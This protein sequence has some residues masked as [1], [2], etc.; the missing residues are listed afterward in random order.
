MQAVIRSGNKQ[1]LVTPGQVLE[2]DL[3]DADAKTLTFEPL[4]VVDGDKITVGTPV[5]A[6]VTVAAE[7]VAEVKGDKL[8]VLKFQPKKR[9]KKLTGHRQHYTQVKI[10][11]VG[12]AKAPVAKSVTA[13]KS[14]PTAK[15]AKQPAAK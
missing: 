13:K 14:V 12:S 4:L 2:I 9:V 15:I 11:A 6:G 7:V 5:V 3:V 10:T 8:K 1:Y